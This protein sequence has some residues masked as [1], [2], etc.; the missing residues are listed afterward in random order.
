MTRPVPGTHDD[1]PGR[2][3]RAR[4]VVPVS[5]PPLDDGAVELRGGCI[6][7][8]GRWADLARE[9]TASAVQDL[10]DVV[11]L[12]GLVNAH[13]HLDYTRLAGQIAPTRS[14]ADW[15]KSILAA[16]S[17]WSD[18]DFEPSWREG[19]LQMLATG[20]TSVANIESMP[21][22]VPGL[23]A[24]TP[25]GVHSFVEITG[26][27]SRRDPSEML[28]EALAH[29]E[30]WIPAVDK[31]GPGRARQGGVGLSPHAPYSTSPGLLA[32][33]PEAARG[34]G[35]RV[36]MHVAESHEE[37]E[38]FMYRRGAMHE[39]LRGQR[40]D[41]DC[42]HGS[43]VRHVARH[44]LLGPGF[45]AVHVNYLWD[46][47][48]RLLGDAGAH[49]VH[50]PRSH[51][52]FRHQRFPA[53][54]LADAGVNL[55][56]GTDSLASTLPGPG[57]R[58][59]VLSMFDEMAA[60]LAQDATVSPAA[61]LTMATVHGARALGLPPGTGTLSEGAPADLCAVPDMASAGDVHEVLAAHRGEVLGTWIAGERVWGG[62]G[63]DAEEG[64][65][66][67]A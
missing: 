62:P 20:T 38:M 7:R 14:F 50:C 2:I 39:W 56:L 21:A 42:G 49:V 12:P 32:L 37:F 55:C 58:P 26:V 3:L 65:V 31:A 67:L 36:T 66:D 48:A 33:T 9:G 64:T 60:Y 34:R 22:L 6:V 30:A 59:P 53:A 41:D 35:C 29:L 27:R 54:E 18:A 57:G 15:I 11:L 46:G 45:L 43:P 25:L 17:A 51:A 52:Y 47:D 1:P 40:P 23:R 19:A 63:R 8:V 16:K 28:R 13:A 61:V 10:G 24:G 4:R 44:G 5:S